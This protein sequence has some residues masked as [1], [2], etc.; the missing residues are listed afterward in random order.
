MAARYRHGYISMGNLPTI[1]K[2]PGGYYRLA[3]ESETV[4]SPI[5]ILSCQLHKSIRIFLLWPG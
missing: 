1:G 2:S 3:R 4:E 5:G